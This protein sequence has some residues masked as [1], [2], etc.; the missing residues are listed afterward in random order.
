MSIFK[1][2]T[3]SGKTCQVTGSQYLEDFTDKANKILTSSD[4]ISEKIETIEVVDDTE[5]LQYTL[6]HCNITVKS[7][8]I[9]LNV[10]EE[11]LTLFDDYVQFQKKASEYKG[12]YL[13]EDYLIIYN[14]IDEFFEYELDDYP[15]REDKEVDIYFDFDYKKI[16]NLDYMRK[17]LLAA[18]NTYQASN[19]V[20]FII[21]EI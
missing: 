19:G 4:W 17:E 11:Y 2:T 8:L 9:S 1:F 7:Y 14:S 6:H 15:F 16:Y 3:Y 12:S 21:L 13:N 18:E 10:F 5:T 20:F